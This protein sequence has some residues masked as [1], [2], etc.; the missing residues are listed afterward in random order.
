VDDE[1]RTLGMPMGEAWRV[2][3]GAQWR[4]SEAISLGAAGELMWM[5]D[6]PVNQESVFRGRV[7]GSFDDSWFSFFTVNLSWTF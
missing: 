3:L 2:G 4:V 1:N 7:S 6:L 5:G